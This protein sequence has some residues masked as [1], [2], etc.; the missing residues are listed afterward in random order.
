YKAGIDASANN[1]DVVTTGNDDAGYLGNLLGGRLDFYPHGNF[2]MAQGDFAHTGFPLVGVGA[3]AYVWNNDNDD[4]VDAAGDYDNIN[5][6][7]VDGAI[8]WRGWS[9]D[10]AWQ[11]FTTETLDPAFTGG[12]VGNGEGDFDTWSVEGGYMLVANRFEIVA[13]YQVLDADVLADEDRRI[14]VGCNWFFDK[15]N[16]KL[17]FTWEMGDNVFDVDGNTL[18]F[19]DQDR[20][21]FQLQHVL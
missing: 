4:V 15:H 13:G 18:R 14:S 12:L 2:R 3:N 19:E 5:G 16:T 11:Q 6:I 1:V 17:Q 10:L 21:F 8:R 20:I 7:G 9:V